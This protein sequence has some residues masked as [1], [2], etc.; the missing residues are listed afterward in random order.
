[1]RECQGHR[2]E[3]TGI[4]PG[5]ISPHL[6]VLGSESDIGHSA[7]GDRDASGTIGT[8]R[9]RRRTVDRGRD[10]GVGGPLPTVMEE[11]AGGLRRLL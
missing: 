7:T 10:Q 5:T 11:K 2:D 4:D 1:V 8:G 3:V 6:W 9:G